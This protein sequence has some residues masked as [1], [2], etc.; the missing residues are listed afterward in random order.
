MQAACIAGLLLAAAVSGQ[1][2]QKDGYMNC[3]DAPLC[4]VLTLETG[5]GPGAYKHDCAPAPKS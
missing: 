3:G 5:L 4:G 1:V 2:A